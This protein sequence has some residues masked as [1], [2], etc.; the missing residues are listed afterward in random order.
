MPP[1]QRGAPDGRQLFVYYRVAL[2]DLGACV[3]A[4]RAFQAELRRT[5]PDLLCALLQRPQSQDV[6]G[7]RTLMETYARS[8][9]ID[10][11]LEAHIAHAAA[12]AL[13]LLVAGPRRVEVF[14]PCA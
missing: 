4:V 14:E 2:P 1:E 7:Q 11:A 13:A 8:G 6:D 9:G 12:T 10:A 5:H 3:L